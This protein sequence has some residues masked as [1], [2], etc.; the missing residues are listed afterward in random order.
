MTPEILY[1][2]NFWGNDTYISS[3]TFK[4]PNILRLIDWLKFN[5]NMISNPYLNEF[6]AVW[7]NLPLMPTVDFNLQFFT[8]ARY[9]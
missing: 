8:V 2:G 7:S 3:P 1:G 9:D 6:I 5:S 4:V